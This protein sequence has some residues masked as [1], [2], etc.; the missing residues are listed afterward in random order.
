MWCVT[1]DFNSIKCLEE[2]NRGGCLISDMRR[3]SELIEDLEL[4]DL[5][6]VG[7]AFYMKWKGK[8]SINVKVESFLSE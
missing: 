7:G 3:F 1:G 4:K 2:C 5:S 8:Q 6:I